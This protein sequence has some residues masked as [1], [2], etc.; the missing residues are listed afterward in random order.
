[1]RASVWDIETRDAAGS[2]LHREG[3]LSHEISAPRWLTNSIPESDLR[4][5]IPAPGPGSRTIVNCDIFQPAYHRKYLRMVEALGRSRLPKQTEIAVVYIHMVSGTG[6]EEND[7]ASID[8]PVRGRVVR[9]RVEAWVDAFGRAGKKLVFTGHLPEKLSFCYARGV[10][11]RNGLVEC[12]LLHTHNPAHGQRMDAD[13]HMIVDVSLPPIARNLIFGD[14]NEEYSA[15]GTLHVDRFGPRTMWNHRYRE[16]TLRMLQMRRNYVWEPYGTTPDP[17]LSGYLA[18]ELGRAVADAPDAWCYLRESYVHKDN[19]GC[20]P[21]VPVRN[22]ERWLVQRDLPG[23]PTEPVR[24]VT[25]KNYRP[26]GDIY[27]CYVPGMNYDFVA[28]RGRRFGF[29]LDDRFVVDGAHPIAFKITYYD[30]AP[31][32]L[33]YP[34]RSGPRSR[35]APARGDGTLRTATFFVPDARLT[36]KHGEPDFE[37]RSVDSLRPATLR[38]VRVVRCGPSGHNP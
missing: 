19:V 25:F 7:G 3:G 34:T 13:G 22:F 37:V 11:Q 23:E 32:A 18:L 21:A 26:A 31:W 10:G 24:K 30:D 2:M 12:C 36:A 8:D 16:A 35:A 27:N 1:M 5:R 17:Y 33:T 4:E 9:E 28:R 20:N 29:A 38:F 15:T 6:G 14:E